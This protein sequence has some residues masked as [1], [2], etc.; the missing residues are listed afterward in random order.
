MLLLLTKKS[1][2]VIRSNFIR[3]T[4]IVDVLIWVEIEDCPLGRPTRF[5]YV[6]YVDIDDCSLGRHL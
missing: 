2:V 4:S 1:G 3:S 6:V 5:D